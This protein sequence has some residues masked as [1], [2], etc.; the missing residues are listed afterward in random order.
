MNIY[1]ENWVKDLNNILPNAGI[2]LHKTFNGFEVGQ[3]ISFTFDDTIGQIKGF[4]YCN[5]TNTVSVILGRTKNDFI[6]MCLPN[7]RAAKDEEKKI[8]NIFA[9]IEGTTQKRN[10]LLL[11]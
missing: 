11:Q 2:L 5:I 8:F 4:Y 7:I 10:I 3:I 6:S 9:D 1:S